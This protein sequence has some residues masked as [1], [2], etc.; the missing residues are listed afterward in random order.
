MGRKLEESKER[1]S[2]G[3]GE[4]R[5]ERVAKKTSE[6]K[7]LEV[8]SAREKTS[9]RENSSSNGYETKLFWEKEFSRKEKR[10]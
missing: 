1:T 10:E 8:P 7:L 4:R 2:S 3:R 5:Q 9:E 6:K